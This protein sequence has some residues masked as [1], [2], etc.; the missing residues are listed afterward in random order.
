MTMQIPEKYPDV[1]A[2]LARQLYAGLVRGGIKPAAAAKV[3]WRSV[4]HVRV[5]IGGVAEYIPKG[6]SYMCSERDREILAKFRGNNYEALA[7]EYNL[8]EMRIR[9]IIATVLEEERARRQADLFGK[10]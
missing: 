4:E 7:R 2:D 10:G 1:L 8:T 9:Q 6:I 3:V 5:T